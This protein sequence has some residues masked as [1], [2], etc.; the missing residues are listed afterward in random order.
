[1]V[2]LFKVQLNFK[3][4]YSC[5]V[6]HDDLYQLLRYFCFLYHVLGSGSELLHNNVVING[7]EDIC[8]LGHAALK[9]EEMVTLNLLLV[10]FKFSSFEGGDV[11]SALRGDQGIWIML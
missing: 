4:F 9:L 1:M 8:K 6:C 7:T 2:L 10:E 5:Q 11:P 3:H